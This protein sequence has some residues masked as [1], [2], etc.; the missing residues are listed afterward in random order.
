MSRTR[1]AVDIGGTFTDLV[2]V[3]G[4]RVTANAKVL[5]TPGDPSIAV[6]TGIGRLLERVGAGN[7]DEVVHGTTLV[8]NALIER[9]GATTAL[10]T[11]TGFRDVLSIRRELRYD[12]Y[13]LFLE[14]PEPLVPRRLRFEATERVL[15]DGTV[16]VALDPEEVRRTA[17]RMDREGVQAVA[18]S[19][20]HAYR[21]PNHEREV[22]GLLRRELPGVAISLS[23]D[24]S[25]ELGEFARTSTVVANAYVLP[26]VA[27]YLEMLAKRLERLGMRGPL[28]IMLSTGAGGLAGV[29]TAS[30][31][32]VRLL[33]SGPAAGALSAGFWGSGSGSRNVLAFD[34]GGTTAKAC[35]IEDGIPM[36]ARE[37]EA[38]RV[39]RFTKGSG[40]PLRVPVIDLIEIGA[41]GGSIAGVGP[42]GL[43]K[44]GPESTGA[45][46]GPACYG[47]GGADP[48]VTDADL[49][50]GYLNP[51]FFLGGEMRLDEGAARRAVGRLAGELGLGVEETAAA[52]HRV[53]NENMASAARMHAIERGR[54]LRRFTLVA[55]GGAGPVHAWGVARAL[56]MSKLVFPPS[57]GVASAF[58]MLT[59]APG[60]EFARSLP[61]PLERTSWEQVRAILGELVEEGMRQLASSGVADAQAR[62]DLA[63]DVRHRGQG[64][65]V[66][67]E[68]GG[69]LSS[70]PAAQIEAAF[71][72]AY[73]D[74][75]GHRPPGVE[76]E[77]MTWRV[78]VM[79]PDPELDV[80]L[81]ERVPGEVRKG[82]RRVW[83]AE[84]GGFVETDV[85]NR[86]RLAPGTE[87]DG[88]A[89]VEE[90]ES[91]MVIGPGAHARVDRLGNLEV[92]AR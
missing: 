64:E 49:V 57:A 11:T 10:V 38:A 68:L 45:D 14:M 21:H 12:L 90:R 63:A 23:S 76:A 70:D 69:E 78:R 22:A 6:E 34:M 8:A 58:G 91:T 26:L 79:G 4:G 54:D 56:G 62:V 40:M 92:E 9:K 89:V 33:E 61:A 72:A 27:G 67:V 50:L 31:Y 51:G 66:T 28:R 15:A 59:A 71:A 39:Y 41:G 3:E 46:P 43:P 87:L 19:L 35:L 13:D 20:L 77:V 25:P 83:F 60:F 48:A 52:I 30:R 82:R 73:T 55:T 84:T 7:V 1:I 29:D 36:V 88:P 81:R 53:V 37:F 65:A 80:T 5:T 42:F 32:P 75:Y 17:R 85:L 18:V 2:L 47:Q 24:V 44:V 74:L 16:E 86:Y